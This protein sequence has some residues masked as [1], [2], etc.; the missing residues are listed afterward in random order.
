MQS[1]ASPAEEN[2]SESKF[3]TRLSSSIKFTPMKERSLNKKE[4]T[5][6]SIAL[7]KGAQKIVDPPVLDTMSELEI[8][9]SPT[10]SVQA[11]VYQSMP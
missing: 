9:S 10:T 4:T 2:D 3:T 7:S 1:N 11:N 6:S 8:C 5:P